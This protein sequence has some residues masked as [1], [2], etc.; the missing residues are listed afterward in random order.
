[1]FNHI[2]FL[3]LSLE[4][5][6]CTWAPVHLAGVCSIAP[7]TG[8]Q[9][10][11]SLVFNFLHLSLQY[12]FHPDP[13]TL[14]DYSIVHRW[15]TGVLKCVH[16]GESVRANYLWVGWLLHT[17]SC[18]LE[19]WHFPLS[20]CIWLVHRLLYTLSLQHCTQVVH[21]SAGECTSRESVWANY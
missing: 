11:G 21:R 15:H 5:I 19:V 3:H 2:K 10:T 6:G 17:D 1:M 13:C 12:S 9:I 18:T 4:E 20:S 14:Q 8:T 7:M 16:R